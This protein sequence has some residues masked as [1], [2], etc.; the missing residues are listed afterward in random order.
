MRAGTEGEAQRQPFARLQLQRNAQQDS[1]VVHPVRPLGQRLRHAVS[2]QREPALRCVSA[3]EPAIDQRRPARLFLHAESPERGVAACRPFRREH[4]RKHQLRRAQDVGKRRELQDPQL[5]C[6]LRRHREGERRGQGLVRCG[7][8]G[9]ALGKAPLRRALRAGKEGPHSVVGHNA[10]CGRRVTENRAVLRGRPG[11]AGL[12]EADVIAAVGQHCAGRGER[13]HTA[14]GA[15][16]AQRLC[17]QPACLRAARTPPDHHAADGHTLREKAQ[18][19]AHSRVLRDPVLHGPA[20]QHRA[21]RRETHAQMMRHHLAHHLA[22][23]AARASGREIQRLIESVFSSHAEPLKLAQ[24]PHR[25]VRLDQQA[26]ECAVGRE[27]QLRVHAAP[28]RQRR[29][30][31]RL[32]AVV[33]LLIQREISAFGDAPRQ[34][35]G[36]APPLA[37]ETKFRALPQQRLSHQRQKQLRHQI[38]EH[39]ARPR[40]HAA[41]AVLLHLRAAELPPESARHVA[42][43]DGEIGR[44]PRL[45]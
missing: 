27:H 29:D 12:G 42:L 8:A 32:V 43:G 40:G 44:Q 39:R 7:H 13:V 25:S 11:G 30:A 34:P 31:V 17:A 6:V 26:Q 15:Q 14:A 4:R 38:L 9:A 28:Q 24:A 5:A 45:A 2:R 35:R 41:V 18:V 37:V 21:D 1:A 23:G 3:R 16:I 20:A 33:Q 36:G 22:A 19:R 10:K